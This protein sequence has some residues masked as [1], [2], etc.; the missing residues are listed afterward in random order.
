[1]THIKEYKHMAYAPF[2]YILLKK[3]L[4]FRNFYMFQNKLPDSKDPIV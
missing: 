4:A 1:M 3:Y 2:V